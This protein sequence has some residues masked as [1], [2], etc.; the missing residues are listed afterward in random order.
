MN[1]LAWRGSTKI[2]QPFEVRD[3]KN[4]LLL[5][6]R[7]DNIAAGKLTFSNTNLSSHYCM[8]STEKLSEAIALIEESRF[9]MIC[10]DYEAAGP[11]TLTLL[12]YSTKALKLNSSTPKIVLTESFAHISSKHRAEILCFASKVTSKT[13]EYFC[14]ENVLNEIENSAEVY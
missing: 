12:E 6:K 4:V 11:N 13:A 10:I 5:T 1:T 2:R 8:I 14:L 7:L 3:Q 9:D